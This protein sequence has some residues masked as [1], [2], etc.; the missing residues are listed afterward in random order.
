MTEAETCLREALALGEGLGDALL[1]G[2][3][4]RHLTN[5]GCLAYTAVGRAEAQAFRSRL[6]QLLVQMGRSPETNCS[7]CLE[8]LALPADGAADDAAG[9]VSGAS[10]GP[11]DSCVYVMGC[12]HQF[13]YSCMESWRRTT[14]S[15]ACPL[16]KK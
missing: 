1:T 13:H 8:P 11:P 5:F 15:S 7:I 4:L 12:D 6:N 2:Q 10:G 3:I 9:G 16:C 14:S